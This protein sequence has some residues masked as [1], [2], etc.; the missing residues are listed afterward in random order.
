M[1]PRNF[2]TFRLKL[3]SSVNTLLVFCTES[4]IRYSIL[5]NIS[6]CDDTA[7]P[8]P[9]PRDRDGARQRYRRK[10]SFATSKKGKKKNL[11]S[12][13][14][15]SD[16]LPIIPDWLTPIKQESVNITP[17]ELPS[18]PIYLVVA[19]GEQMMRTVIEKR[20][21]ARSGG[22]EKERF[23]ALSLPNEELV[24][25]S[26]GLLLNGYMGESFLYIVEWV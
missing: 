19:P 1:D 24:E 21:Q 8:P 3:S 20:V 5:G 14:V 11:P 6:G 22:G 16:N 7:A 10:S 26:Q 17:M 4:D 18:A 12:G 23:D 13:C 25:Y 2:T 15:S 9:I